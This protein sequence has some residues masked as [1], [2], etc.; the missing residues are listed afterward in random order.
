MGRWQQV[1]ADDKHNFTPAPAVDNAVTAAVRGGVVQAGAIDGGVH[2]HAAPDSL[3]VTPLDLLPPDVSDFTGRD[4]EIAALRAELLEG[5]KRA[6]AVTSVVG[7]PGVGK[8]ALA[9]HLAHQ[10]ADQFPDGRLYVNLRGADERP[11]TAFAALGDL[12]HVAF[13]V[14]GDQQPASVEGRALMW[15]RSLA[16]RRI[17][18]VLDNALDAQ[19]VRWLLPGDT[20]CSVLVTSR[21]IIPSI[22]S[23]PLQ[24]D[25]L[26]SDTALALLAKIA[27]VKRI[28]VAAEASHAVVKACGG[29]PLALRIVGA[30]LAARKDW[31]LPK[32]AERLADE[33]RTL[34]ELGTDDLDVR[35]SFQLSYQALS[36]E[37]AR[38]YRL[39]ALWPGP[40]FDVWAL[41]SFL[42]VEYDAAE[43][44]LDALVTAQLIEPI[45]LE[46]FGL[47]DLLRLFAHERLHQ[48]ESQENRYA[49]RTRMIRAA[50]NKA[51]E[52]SLAWHGEDQDEAEAA[53][54]WLETERA[55]LVA[56]VTCTTFNEVSLD[57]DIR[58]L[59]N[60]LRDFLSYRLHRRDLTLVSEAAVANSER[61]G[62]RAAQINDYFALAS[63][64]EQE[65]RYDDAEAA[66]N[67]CLSVARVVRDQINE[68]VCFCRLARLH[69]ERGRY[70]DAERVLNEGLLFAREAKNEHHQAILLAELAELSRTLNRLDDAERAIKDGLTISRRLKYGDHVAECQG[71]LGIARWRS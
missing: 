13:D 29:L 37:Y 70:D 19:Q 4:S 1:T 2:I 10:L 60:A 27:G 8:S 41:A 52:M 46:R 12:I 48:E 59:A 51:N 43:E 71:T 45:A 20:T 3:R 5:P 33:R 28:H 63:A 40:G 7:K 16:G 18:V 42:D 22:S 31:T 23:K 67:R 69:R 57:A 32:V 36:D 62:D 58:Q 56:L 64:Y 66:L 9:I 14:A 50:L 34:R 55:G 54:R 21:S 39:L 17:L 35:A 6:V 11:L 49:A 25:V 38:A 26:P 53:L 68:D 61:T 44:I 24:L 65:D 30:K 47:H 15:R